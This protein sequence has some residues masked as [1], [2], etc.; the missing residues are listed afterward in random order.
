M[1]TY[2]ITNLVTDTA[3]LN[4]G[5]G[6]TAASHV[7]A[8]LLNPWGISFPPNAPVW[9][10]NNGSQT[11]T[12]YD[13]EGDAEPL[14]VTLPDQTS[15]P[16]GIQA[17]NPSGVVFNS[18]DSSDFV[19]GSGPASFLFDGEDGIIY[20]WSHAAGAVIV[21]TAADGA[22]YKGLTLANSGGSNYLYATDFEN[23]KVDVFDHQFNK[24][25]NTTTFPFVDPQLPTGYAPYGI[26]AVATGTAGALQIVVTYAKPDGGSPVPDNFGGAGLGLVDLYDTSGTFIKT[27]VPAGGVLNGPWGIALAPSDFGALS[28]AL[29]IGNFGDGSGNAGGGQIDAF[30][31]S[32]GASLGTI[33]GA[34]G[35]PLV[36][37]GLWGLAFGNDATGLQQPHNTLFF[38]AGTDDEADGTYGRIDLG[39]TAPTLP[40]SL[41]IT[42]P[43][44]GA[45]VSGTVTVTAQVQD[46]AVVAS[47]Q[48]F[49]NST[50]IGQ[51]SQAPF[52]L[53]WD[54]TSSG[55]GSIAL[56]ATASDSAGNPLS[57]SAVDVTV[58][59][60]APP[61]T[62]TQLQ[63]QFFT[64]IC[65]VCHT[66]IGSGL[67]GSQNL[68]AGNAYS[69]IVNV[70]SVEQ[71]SLLR[72]KPNDPTNSYLIQKIEGA[73]GISG[74]RMPDGCPNS[75][76]CLTQDQI[77]MFI[78]WVNSGAPN[79]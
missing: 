70:S 44:A 8:N 46:V 11:S 28:G 18:G 7:D 66:G 42:A 2:S 41:S 32:S 19:I 63:T 57:A 45:T 50:S 29:L 43:A 27:I 68:T 15:N 1:A 73:A 56:T 13:G 49:A 78:S 53:Q 79:N 24:V 54:T 26:Q 21:Y 25:S 75:Q 76:P 14:V 23:N 36:I 4:S 39:A 35:N 47:V 52:N 62:L 60:A 10:A 64:P 40:S 72:I 48:F 34:S 59:N 51:A 61:T 37:P 12:L 30:D 20:G 3:N 17:A 33:N 31:P 22:S 6:A 69:N 65:S 16:A 58:S 5:D 67:P 9:L 55:N 38:T 74:A 71:P 77:N